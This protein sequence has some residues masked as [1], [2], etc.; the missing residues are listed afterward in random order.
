M[1]G[2]E[3]ERF[4]ATLYACCKATGIQRIRR[5]AYDNSQQIKRDG[6]GK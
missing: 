2:L 5:L 4:Q 1:E 6:S 3:R